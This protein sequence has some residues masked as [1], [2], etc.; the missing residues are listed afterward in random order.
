MAG[1]RSST[2]ALARLA[3]I[4]LILFSALGTDA[5]RGAAP[6]YTVIDLGTFGTVQ[7][8]QAFDVNDARPGRGRRR[9]QPR[10]PL[11]ERH[12]DRSRYPGQRVVRL[13]LGDQRSRPGCRLF[14]AHDAAIGDRMR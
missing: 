1:S 4:A 6:P 8:A 2:A 14:R 13:G 11:A 5:P 3:T 9:R 10:I 12:E 7:S